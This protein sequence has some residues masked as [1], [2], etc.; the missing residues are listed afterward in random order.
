MFGIRYYALVL[1]LRRLESGYQTITLVSFGLHFAAST[2][3]MTWLE[4]FAATI[5][6]T[7]PLRTYFVPLINGTSI[8][9]MVM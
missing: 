9:G 7:T 5:G 1:G 4:R 6:D 2:T 8:I 3:L